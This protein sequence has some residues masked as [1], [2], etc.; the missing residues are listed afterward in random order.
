[1]LPRLRHAGRRIAVALTAV[2]VPLA[3]VGWLY[4][5]RGAVPVS[6]PR[7]HDALPHDELSALDAVP[8]LVFVVVW[9]AAAVILGLVAR[10]ARIE[11][12]TAGLVYA[13][14]AGAV[15]YLTAALSLF[16][17]R[18][19]PIV[20][21]LVAAASLGAV[22]L[23]AA[24]AGLGGA[25]LGAP[26]QSGRPPW[27]V[28]LA[29][30]VAA[31]GL[32]TVMS[33]VVPRSFSELEVVEGATRTFALAFASAFAVPAGLMAVLLAR[34]LWRRRR[35]A[36]ELTLLLVLATAA[37]HLFKASYAGAA[38]DLLIAALLLARRGDFSG[39]GDPVARRHLPVRALLWAGAIFLYGFL[40]IW[41]NRMFLDRA[42]TPQF[43]LRETAAALVGRGFTRHHIFG[44][45]GHWFHLSV[46]LLGILA[47]FSLLWE[48]LAPWRYRLAQPQRERER[49]QALVREF[50]VDSLAPFVL[51][52]DNSYYFSDDGRAVLA[53]KVVAAVAVVSGDPIGPEGS[54]RSLLPRFI[55]FARERDWRV[56]MLG[57]G[58]R[59]LALYR[60]LDLH[61]IYHGD[62]AVVDVPGFSLEG[63][64]IR[65]VRQSVARLER[66][67]YTAEVTYAGEVGE[68]LRAQLQSVFEEWC[69]G[70]TTKGHTMELDTLFRLE[71][72]DAL[73]VIGRDRDGR[74]HGFLHYVC[75]PAARTLSLSSMPRRRE[76]PNGFTEFLVVRAIEW[77]K[78]HGFERLSMNYVPYASVFDDEGE[79]GTR[80]WLQRTALSTLKG[81]GFQ[82]ENLFV[83]SRKFFPRWEHRYVV[84][85]RTTDLPQVTV[86]G[87]AAEGYLPLGA[88]K[89]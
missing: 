8:V 46:F 86:A 78:A 52:A 12:L 82:L 43:A 16:T 40:A 10:A 60:E 55:E 53:Y 42:F 36:W 73:F 17:V 62:E 48:W 37:L 3:A 29:A 79:G 45:F 67:G 14:V 63:R 24:F 76:T 33:A 19:V 64:A 31:S 71:G 77:A 34:G 28:L 88:V 23:G 11:R 74:P 22:Y 38:V 30:F 56:A 5:A 15:L 75:L 89:R 87:L 49:V 6:G 9:G 69:G 68:D 50:G 54:V 13:A 32:L 44:D 84:Y 57:A 21:A 18:Q 72:R 39:P 20:D 47:A 25:L 61:A 27:P 41:I 66:E 4:L 70:S 7:V 81:R 26:K 59:Y 2:L 85:E 83:F 58:E 51:R 65:K 80:R 1:M 35:R